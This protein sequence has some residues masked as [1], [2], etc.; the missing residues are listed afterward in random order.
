VTRPWLSASFGGGSYAMDTAN[1]DITRTATEGGVAADEITSGLG[2]DVAA[3]LDVGSVFRMGLHFQRIYADAMLTDG[4]A[5][6][7]YRYPAA[8]IYLS[9]AAMRPAGD[10]FG[11]GIDLGVGLT[12]S[13][14]EVEVSGTGLTDRTN[15]LGGTGPYL[16]ARGL[17]DVRLTNLLE[18][19]MSA[20]YRYAN[21][22][23]MSADGVPI[24]DNDNQPFSIDYS[25]FEGQAGIRFYFVGAGE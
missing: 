8:A 9:M 21:T 18:L 1:T 16:A 7:D 10:R 12:L 15:D 13:A 2:F 3:G 20:G 5:S 4:T 14:A 22:N 11:Y 23:E 6:V 17:F 25:G 24:K 19:T